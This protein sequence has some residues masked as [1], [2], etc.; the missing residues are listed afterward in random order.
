M[1]CLVTKALVH[2]HFGFVTLVKQLAQRLQFASCLSTQGDEY[3]KNATL[4]YVVAGKLEKVDNIWIEEM[5]SEEEHA[6][7]QVEDSGSRVVWTLC[8]FPFEKTLACVPSLHGFRAFARV[9]ATLWSIPTLLY[10]T[11][12][13]EAG[14]GNGMSVGLSTIPSRCFS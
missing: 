10:T 12:S 2:G 11:G 14:F 9:T 5:S 8:S 1:D 6:V 13:S 3:R 4:A 7:H